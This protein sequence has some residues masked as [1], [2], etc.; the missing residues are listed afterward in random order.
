MKVPFGPEAAS[1]GGRL[2]PAFATL[3]DMN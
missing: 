3:Q 2:S 1:R